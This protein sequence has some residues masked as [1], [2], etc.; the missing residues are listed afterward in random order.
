[1]MEAY[2]VVP[3]DDDSL[4]GDIEIKPPRA[5]DAALDRVREP[6]ICIDSTWYILATP[7]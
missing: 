3:R 4:F 5:E 7:L 2:G 1:M 6:F